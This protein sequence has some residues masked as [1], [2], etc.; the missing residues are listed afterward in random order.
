MRDTNYKVGDWVFCEFKLQ[1]IREINESFVSVTD[2]MFEMSMSKY[3]FD[4]NSF[5]LEMRIKRISDA[6]LAHAERVHKEVIHNGVNYRAI[7]D[8]MIEKWVIAC[9]YEDENQSRRVTGEMVQFCDE[10]IKKVQ[11]VRGMDFY[12]FKLFR[13]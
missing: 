4:S 13:S 9:Q 10:V 8:R 6:F 2:G 5:P 7:Y 1:Q 12:G 11:E 3:H